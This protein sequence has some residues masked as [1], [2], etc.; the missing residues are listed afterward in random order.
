MAG[1]SGFLCQDQYIKSVQYAEA[2][3]QKHNFNYLKYII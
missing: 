2:D 3:L 1:K